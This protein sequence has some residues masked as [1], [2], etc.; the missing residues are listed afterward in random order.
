MSMTAVARR[1]ARVDEKLFTTGK[2]VTDL[3]KLEGA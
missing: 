3:S 1:I 2:I